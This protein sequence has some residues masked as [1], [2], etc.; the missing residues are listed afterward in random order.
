MK[1]Q[2]TTL[3]PFDILHKIANLTIYTRVSMSKAKIASDPLVTTQSAKH[4]ELWSAIFKCDK[5]I[6]KVMAIDYGMSAN[7]EPCLIGKRMKSGKKSGKKRTY[8]I[9]LINDWDGDV[10]YEKDLFFKSLQKFEHD[11]RDKN[12]IHFT[13]S[14]ISL[15]IQDAVSSTL[16]LVIQD[17]STYI[18]KNR[19]TL[20]TYAC[21]YSD[22]KFI[23]LGPDDIG[24]IEGQRSKKAIREV[25]CIK[26]R[27][28][29]G[30]QIYRQ[31]DKGKPLT[32]LLPNRVQVDGRECV[33]SWKQV[34]N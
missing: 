34:V 31:F 22:Q 12:L 8:L 17:L 32:G 27:F 24:G 11:E 9:L 1:S 16:D 15:H 10:R 21:Y 30:T 18:F 5:W 25:V 4:V 28:R 29:E 23:K 19:G 26:V 13:D 14:S 33:R 3:L 20:S 7:P 2:P 6:N